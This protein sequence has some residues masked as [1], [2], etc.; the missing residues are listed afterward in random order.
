MSKERSKVLG[1]PSRPPEPTPRHRSSNIPSASGRV[2]IRHC[3]GKRHPDNGFTIPGRNRI[4]PIARPGRTGNKVTLLP[5]PQRRLQ[6]CCEHAAPPAATAA[7]RGHRRQCRRAGAG[8]GGNERAVGFVKSCRAQGT[9]ES[10]SFP[11]PCPHRA[12]A[13]PG[14]GCHDP[15]QIGSASSSTLPSPPLPTVQADTAQPSRQIAL[16]MPIHLTF[17]HPSPVN[18]ASVYRWG[19]RGREKQ[20]A[21][22]PQQTRDTALYLCLNYK[23]TSAH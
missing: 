16:Q 20:R 4:K 15:A 19:N 18:G 5:S 8:A 7:V 2:S 9:S 6:P 11:Q 10:V 12:A 1:A 3:R 23:V 22:R 14:Y 17:Q 13:P 21:Q